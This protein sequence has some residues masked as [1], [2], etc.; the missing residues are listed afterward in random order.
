MNATKPFPA[1]AAALAATVAAAV[2]SAGFGPQNVGAQPAGSPEWQ[3][4][5]GA[6]AQARD[7]GESEAIDAALK[8]AD[9]FVAAHPGD[10][11][12]LTYRG[13]LA[14]MRAKVSLMPWTKLAMLHEGIQQMDDGVDR[15][16]RD[17]A[18][19]GG[20]IELDVRMVRGITSARIPRAFGRGSVAVADFRSVAASSHF[21][22]MLP[23]HRATAL[24]W[25]AVLA[26]RQGDEKAGGDYL[27][28]AR[29]FD[30][31]TASSIWENFQ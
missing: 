9:G 14:A 17:K 27:A 13:S 8:L 19:A 1:R 18:L 29:G 4:V 28:R 24:A 2:V 10:G 22:Q 31:V 6:Y 21:D 30:A 20:E 16:L 23:A 7:R 26:K 11:R 12:A 15:V 5:Q 25:L 3:R